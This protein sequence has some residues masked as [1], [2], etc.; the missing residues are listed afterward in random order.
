[1][2]TLLPEDVVEAPELLVLA[3]LEPTLHAL[4]IALVV[5]YP[6]LLNERGRERDPPALATARQLLQRA[7]RLGRAIDQYRRDL[8]RARTLR[9][10]SY[11]DIPF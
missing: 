10:Q 8:E 1:M 3:S 7:H 9:E 2:R 11:D 6:E 4:P 5:A